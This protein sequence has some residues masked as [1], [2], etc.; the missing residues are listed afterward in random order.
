M[1][2]STLN[3]L[4]EFMKEKDDQL[5][6]FEELRLKA[7]QEEEARVVATMADF[8]EDW[9]HSQVDALAAGVTMRAVL[10]F[11]ACGSFGIRTRRPASLPPPCWT[12]SPRARQ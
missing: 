4:A 1:A 3:A 8:E 6:R 7:Q 9:N 10:I 11:L 5:R 2:P 12:A